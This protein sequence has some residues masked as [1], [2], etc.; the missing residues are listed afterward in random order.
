VPQGEG[1]TRAGAAPGDAVFVTGTLGDCAAAL[2]I[3]LGKNSILEMSD[4]LLQRFYCPQPQ[5]QAGLT[6][7]PVASAC[8]DISDGLVAD[9]GHL[10]KASGVTAAIQAQLL[11]IAEDVRNFANFSDNFSALD[12]ALTGGDDYQL[13]F[14]VAPESLSIV[15]DWIEQGQLQA[16]RIGVLSAGDKSIDPVTV[17]DKNNKILIIEKA[18]YNHFGH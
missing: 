6:L 2:N 11:P 9:L 13:C 14:T 8:I 5:I 4:R 7:R 10:C 17:V 18:G 12:W 15:D 16:T 1:L 3:I